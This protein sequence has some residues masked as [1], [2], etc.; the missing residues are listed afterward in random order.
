M[1]EGVTR[2]L[3]HWPKGTEHTV[4]HAGEN[5]ESAVVGLKAL[6]DQEGHAYAGY[7]SG[8]AEGEASIVIVRPE[9]M[10]GAVVSEAEGIERYCKL[11]FL[12][13]RAQVAAA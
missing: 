6:G 8:M 13:P 9:G 7:A 5:E 3:G 10:I 1:H 12:D 11:I 4:L 2:V